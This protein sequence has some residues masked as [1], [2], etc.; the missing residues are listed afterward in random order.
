MEQVAWASENFWN[1]DFTINFHGSS[2]NIHEWF[3]EQFQDFQ[4]AF[5]KMIATI[6]VIINPTC[7]CGGRMYRDWRVDVILSSAVYIY[8][9]SVVLD[10]NV[11][12]NNL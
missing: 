12:P 6:E 7:H 11:V 3:S 1:F 8:S 2:Q 10:L 9:F 5:D 4:T